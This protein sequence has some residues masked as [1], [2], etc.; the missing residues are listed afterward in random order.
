MKKSILTFILAVV[1][2][3]FS[4]SADTKTVN[5]STAYTGI[6][7]SAGVKVTYL[8]GKTKS[9]TITIDGPADRINNIQASVTDKSLNITVV[10]NKN[11]RAGNLAKGVTITVRGPL[12]PNIA[13]S[14]GATI[15]SS[16]WFE[17]K[18]SAV[19]LAASS[20]G[21]IIF[22]IIKCKT[23]N[24]AASSSGN[25]KL[26]S[27]NATSVNL[28]A[29]SSGDVKVD[30]VKAPTVNAAA[31]SS[32]D[33]RVNTLT[34]TTLNATASSSGDTKVSQLNT[35]SLNCVASSGGDITLAGK[36]Q[37]GT[38]HASSG[39]EVEAWNL[40]VKQTNVRQSSGGSV[41]LR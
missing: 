34:S 22:P 24:I 1:A 3:V 4:M 28:A 38:F 8:P 15:T 12:V 9:T 35:T 32:G 30:E 41:H 25:I 5:I 2:G 11:M 20:S 16:K 6:H 33:V 26:Q 14:S 29:S 13:A 39:G 36:A 7:V 21:D 31:S 10:K 27:V 40:D 18:K 37:T 19:N 17:F 23:I